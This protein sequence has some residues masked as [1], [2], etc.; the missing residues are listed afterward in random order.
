VE[1]LNAALS[2]AFADLAR[3]FFRVVGTTK[4][5]MMLG[6]TLPGF[7]LGAFPELGPSRSSMLRHA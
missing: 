4:M 6:F 1:S 3:G 5:T 2:G 7:N